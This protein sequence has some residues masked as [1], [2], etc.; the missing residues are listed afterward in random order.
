MKL[1]LS[2]ILTLSL[3]VNRISDLPYLD[4]KVEYI[5][6]SSPADIMDVDAPVISLDVDN[7][8][9]SLKR[10]LSSMYSNAT[11]G[12][13]PIVGRDSVDS[14]GGLRMYGYIACKELEHGL[15][16]SLSGDPSIVTFRT[17]SLLRSAGLHDVS[18]GHTRTSSE[19]AGAGAANDFSW[20][21]D[22]AP[23]VLNVR[24]PL[25][26]VH[27]VIAFFPFIIERD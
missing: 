9:G 15:A 13:F 2:I 7:T 11:G 23:L 19:V 6:E 26:L 3:N 12:G 8:I 1:M 16:R 17:A 24:S 10:Q 22:S 4:A 5:H 20:L 18:R 21:V 14:G 27:Q 25:E